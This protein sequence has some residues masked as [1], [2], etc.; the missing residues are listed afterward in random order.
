MNT[1]FSLNFLCKHKVSSQALSDFIMERK[2]LQTLQG[3]TRINLL[4]LSRLISKTIPEACFP[5]GLD[6]MSKFPTVKSPQP[7]KK[8]KKLTT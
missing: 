5:P 6:D 2:R 1:H 4:F 7:K 3:V 8:K